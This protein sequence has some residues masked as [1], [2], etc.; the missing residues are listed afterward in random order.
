MKKSIINTI[1]ALAFV[2]G[3]VV[4][5][6]AQWWAVWFICFPAMV[7]AAL[8]L[9]RVNTNYIQSAGTPRL[10]RE[11]YDRL[12]WWEQEKLLT[13]RDREAI[14]VARDM[15]WAEID[16]GTADSDAGRFALHDLR[17]KKYHREEFGDG[18]L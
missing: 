14:R 15:N 1:L 2:A 13:P 3:L 12:P 11:E 18:I 7:A 17:V 16:E 9:I 6:S 8:V 4:C 5:I 10:T